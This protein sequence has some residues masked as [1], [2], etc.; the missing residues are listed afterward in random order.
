M[1]AWVVRT[2]VAMV[3][4]LKDLPLW[5]VSVLPAFLLCTRFLSREAWMVLEGLTG[6]VGEGGTN[7]LLLTPRPRRPRAP[8]RPHPPLIKL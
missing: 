1:C 4:Y 2:A 3:T 5:P 7:G 8:P 6:P